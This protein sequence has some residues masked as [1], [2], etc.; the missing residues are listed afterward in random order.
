MAST[1]PWKLLDR[2]SRIPERELAGLLG[3][4]RIFGS[5][6]PHEINRNPARLVA[7]MRRLL[8]TN[9]PFTFSS[10]PPAYL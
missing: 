1:L 10:L 4:F 6:G 3:M 8:D 2:I 7:R 5:A 9:R